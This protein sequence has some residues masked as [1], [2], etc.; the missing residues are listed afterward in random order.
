MNIVWKLIL[1]GFLP[2]IRIFADYKLIDLEPSHF[3]GLSTS[4]KLLFIGCASRDRIHL[5]TREK[6]FNTTGGAAFYSALAACAAGAEVTL[7]APKPDFEFCKNLDSLKFEWIGPKTSSDAFPHLEIIH[8][9]NDRAT[10]IAAS[11]AAE[12]EL[13]P[14]YLP[15]NLDEF[16]IVHIAALSSAKRQLD[17]LRAIKHQ[18]KCK[19]SAGTYGK[20][21]YGETVAVREL[22][23]NCDFIFMNENESNALFDTLNFPLKPIAKQIICVTQGRLGATIYSGET[24]INASAKE[25][26]EFDPTGAGD[27][28]AGT[29]LASIDH[30]GSLDEVLRLSLDRATLNI[31]KEG[32]EAIL[33]LLADAGSRRN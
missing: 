7:L 18:S 11:W 19:I 15:A 17:F 30:L 29:F 13:S 26:I 10:L 3:H 31:T 23:S 4:M 5:E 6:S 12:S 27:T 9:G 8:H 20:I 28:F 24:S 21:A 16:D 1:D 14:A 2:S 22:F 25:V 33:E 32:P